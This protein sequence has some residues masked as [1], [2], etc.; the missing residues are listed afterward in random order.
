M[1][2]QKAFEF[3]NSSPNARDFLPKARISLNNFSLDGVTGSFTNWSEFG[4]WMHTSLIAGRDVL[5]ESTK[6]KILSLVEGV[7]SPIEKAKIV[8]QFMQNKTRYISV[9]VGIGGWQPIAANEV[10]EV[11]YGDCKGLTNYTKALLDVVGVESYFTLIYGGQK[12]DIDKDFSAFQGNHAI[13]N[14]PNN[15]N[16]IWLECTS[17]TAPF[18]Y[19]GTFTDDRDVL[20]VMPEVVLLNIPPLIRTI[21]IFNIQKVI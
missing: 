17:Q 19:L 11:G 1:Q 7:N 20:V 9:Q 12:R 2:N 8:Y 4:K 21:L 14:I 18:G 3:E 10:D 16:D 6:S 13:L 5:D 15:G